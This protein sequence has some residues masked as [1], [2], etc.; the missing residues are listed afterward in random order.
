M[1]LEHIALQ[2]AQPAEMAAWYC[3]NFDMRIMHQVEEFC[4]FIADDRGSMLEIYHNPD[5]P[6]PDYA[7]QTPI[8]MHV[9]FWSDD[10][11]ADCERLE[12][13]GAAVIGEPS[14]DADGLGHAFLRDPWDVVL[15]VIRR[16]KPFV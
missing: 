2:V 5:E 16:A 3:E 15:Q 10:V 1:R 12:A 8:Q 9:A 13:A 6:V 14:L 4:F 11:L 7:A